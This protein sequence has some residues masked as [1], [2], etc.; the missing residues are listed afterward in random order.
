[1]E[2]LERPVSK[3]EQ[4]GKDAIQEGGLLDQFL[5]VYNSQ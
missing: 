2:V 3:E 5:V 1:M 4:W